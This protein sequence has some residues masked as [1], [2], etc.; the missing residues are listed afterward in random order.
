M[1]TIIVLSLA[2]WRIS[3]MLIK[4]EGPSKIFERIR[5]EHCGVYWLP[6]GSLMTNSSFCFGL[7]C[8]D[9]NSVWVGVMFSFL[10]LLNKKLAYI[11]A[12]PFCLS[13]LSIVVR[14][15]MRDPDAA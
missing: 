15:V 11:L 5:E 13:A 8:S 14:K 6:D 3:R 10:Y 9:C 2:T 1:R 7:M 4:E 12:L